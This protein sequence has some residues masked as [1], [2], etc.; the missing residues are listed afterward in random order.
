MNR[1]IFAVLL[2]LCAACHVDQPSPPGERTAERPPPRDTL[3]PVVADQPVVAAE[4]QPP[5]VHRPE[6][7][8]FPPPEHPAAYL[9][10]TVDTMYAPQTVWLDTAGV[11]VAT[12]PGI[13]IAAGKHLWKW[14]D[15]EKRVKG[16]DCECYRQH[17][18]ATGCIVSGNAGVAYLRDLTGGAGRV[19]V[20]EA[21]DETGWALPVQSAR[22]VSGAGPY[23]VTSAIGDYDGCGAHDLPSAWRNEFDLSTGE[24]LEIHDTV[25]VY[26]RNG[27]A[28]AAAFDATPSG[29]PEDTPGPGG[30]M[31]YEFQWTRAGRLQGGYR[32]QVFACFA[33]SDDASY[34]RT[35]LVPDPQLPRWIRPW[36]R[37]PRA[38]V[39]YW[40]A[41]RRLRPGWR[42]V[43]DC[44]HASPGDVKG[45]Y[46]GRKHTGWSA[47]DSANAA[48]ML[49][50]FAPTPASAGSASAAPGARPDSVASDTA[51]V[52]TPGTRSIP[53]RRR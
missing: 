23:L 5:P 16:L 21:G 7:A 33:C 50:S 28:A 9:V 4:P 22:P 1:G 14:V 8:G 26:E 6:P 38:V 31:G 3:A 42:D 17:E 19:W 41:D 24:P 15:A 25:G 2:A 40:R 51:A 53:W 44:A 39:A 46:Y 47:V 12:R 43:A 52:D 18:S 36:S 32:F 27:E 35:V 34:S 49:A 45:W 11:V 13:Y 37:A 48:V 20:L 30:L 29:M 10:W